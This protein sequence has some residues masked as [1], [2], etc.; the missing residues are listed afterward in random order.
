M[1][2]PKAFVLMPFDEEFDDIY[3]YLIHDPLSEAGYDVKRADDILNQ[4]NI[5]ADIIQSIINSD[6]IVADLS[7]T[8]PNVYYELGIA[9]S[10]R[11]NVIMLTQNVKELPFDLRSYRIIPYSNHFA[12]MD[13]ARQQIQKLIKDVLDGNGKF[14]N[15]VTD[16]NSSGSDSSTFDTLS[17]VTPEG[18]DDLGLIDHAIELEDNLKVMTDIIA[19]VGDH[20]N[21]LTSD[22]ESAVGRIEGVEK[23]APRKQR[24]TW[25]SLA[26]KFDEFT[27]W[28]QNSNGQYRGALENVVQSIDVILSGEFDITEQDK[29]NLVEFVQELNNTEEAMIELRSSCKEVVTAMDSIPRVEK[30]F[31]RAKRLMSNEIKIF[32]DN[33]DQTESMTMRAQNAAKRFI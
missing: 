8:N 3:D 17:Q 26:A 23:D 33:I 19:G 11:K 31:H 22:M 6:L 27:S 15:P 2:K 5:L 25:Q 24:K 28:L 10:H 21:A 18:Q 1:E 32:I 29:A 7:T 20:C 13:E 16:F 12:K 14:G 30:E 4:G 9:H